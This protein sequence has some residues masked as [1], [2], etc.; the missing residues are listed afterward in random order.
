[1]LIFYSWGY[2]CVFTRIESAEISLADVA[3]IMCIRAAESAT[4]PT[5]GCACLLHTPTKQF[6]KVMWHLMTNSPKKM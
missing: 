2:K 3:I 1:M 4:N 5:F 6:F